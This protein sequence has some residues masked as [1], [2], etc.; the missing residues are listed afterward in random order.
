MM[1]TML[2]FLVI[3][4]TSIYFLRF[5]GVMVVPLNYLKYLGV[6]GKFYLGCVYHFKCIVTVI[7]CYTLTLPALIMLIPYC[8]SYKIN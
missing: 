6:L 8:N 1:N 3:F 7:P 2:S 4:G 5:C